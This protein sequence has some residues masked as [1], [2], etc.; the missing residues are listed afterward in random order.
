MVGKFELMVIVV[1]KWSVECRNIFN[2]FYYSGEGNRDVGAQNWFLEAGKK[3]N[4][5]AACPSFFYFFLEFVKK[6]LISD[7]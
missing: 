5:V 6:I 2:F 1:N 4:N 3:T 7:Q